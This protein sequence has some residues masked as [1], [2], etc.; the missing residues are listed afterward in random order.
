VQGTVVIMHFLSEGGSRS[1]KNM[2]MNW[3]IWRRLFD[4]GKF[5]DAVLIWD[6]RGRTSC[7]CGCQFGVDVSVIVGSAI[8]DW[9]LLSCGE[10]QTLLSCGEWHHNHT[11]LQLATFSFEEPAAPSS[12]QEREV[13]ILQ[14]R[15]EGMG[16]TRPSLLLY[17]FHCF[18]QEA[19]TA[20][21][22]RP[23]VAV[24][25]SAWCHIPEGGYQL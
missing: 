3:N 6:H 20:G 16:W 17:L 1:Y 12:G 24:Q 13:S 14:N 5:P 10:W 23:F 7:L 11:V 2:N 21:S 25:R 9:T 19:G 4:S 22:L 15:N 18:H 8:G